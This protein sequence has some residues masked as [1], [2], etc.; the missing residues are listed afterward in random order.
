[1]EMSNYGLHSFLLTIYGVIIAFSLFISLAF[2]IINSLGFHALAKRRGIPHPGL[3]W[4]PVGGQQWILGS[5]ADQYDYLSEGKTKRQR[6]LLMWLD[7][8]ITA[9]SLI[10]VGLSVAMLI[11]NMDAGNMYGNMALVSSIIST[12]IVY[13]I[14]LAAAIVRAVFYYIALNKV[15]KSCNPENATLYLVLSIL[16]GVTQPFFIFFSRNKDE[17]LPQRGQGPEGAQQI[18]SGPKAAQ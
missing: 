15:Y 14:M 4:V 12:I 9:I 18:G 16:V 11:G 6:L 8:G 2:Y 3:A 7:I 5:L 17:G 13:F 10:Y 1:M